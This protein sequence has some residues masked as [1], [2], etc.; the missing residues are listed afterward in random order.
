MLKHG[1]LFLQC[2]ALHCGWHN[3]LWCHNMTDFAFFSSVFY[4]GWLFHAPRGCCSV[5]WIWQALSANSSLKVWDFRPSVAL[6]RIQD[7]ALMR[8][9]RQVSRGL[10]LSIPWQVSASPLGKLIVYI[11]YLLTHLSLNPRP[12]VP[13]FHQQG[14][15]VGARVQSRTFPY[16]AK[17]S[18]VTEKWTMYTS[19]KK[20]F[21]T[22]ASASWHRDAESN[23]FGCHIMFSVRHVNKSHFLFLACDDIN[24]LNQSTLDVK[25][26]SQ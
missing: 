21:L 16:T 24:M 7:T 18:S 15:G 11:A 26:C 9:V 25:T 23:Y 2:F 8:G 17:G 1:R 14:P 22:A 6:C 19:V 4:N 13:I 10:F 5:K 12:H 3:V 20:K